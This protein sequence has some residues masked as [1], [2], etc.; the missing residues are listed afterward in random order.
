MFLGACAHKAVLKIVLINVVGEL[1]SVF[2][3]ERDTF[4]NIFGDAFFLFV[5]EIQFSCNSITIHLVY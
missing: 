2:V 4:K 3:M 1:K 5:A